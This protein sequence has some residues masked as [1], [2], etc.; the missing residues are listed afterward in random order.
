[1]LQF[2]LDVTEEYVK[3]NKPKANDQSSALILAL[4]L[5]REHV[6]VN[7]KEG[8]LDLKGL[9]DDHKNQVRSAINN[10]STVFDSAM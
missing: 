1:M 8:V 2:F 5:L 10:V 9:T 7:S 3:D 4:D 6:V